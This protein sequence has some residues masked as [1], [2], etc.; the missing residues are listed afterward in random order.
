MLYADCTPPTVERAAAGAARAIEEHSIAMQL[1][2]GCYNRSTQEKLLQETEINLTNFQR[3]MEADET[4]AASSAALRSAQPLASIAMTSSHD[5]TKAQQ[6]PKQQHHTPTGNSSMD[7]SCAGCRGHAYKS[8]NCL[9][10]GKQCKGC[11]ATNHF[12]KV[13]KKSRQK[14]NLLTIGNILHDKSPPHIT[15]AIEIECNGNRITTQVMVDTGADISTVQQR[16]VRHLAATPQ[17]KPTTTT[18]S[19]FDKSV[20]RQVLG[21]LVVTVRHG[22]KKTQA[23]L[24]VVTDD[25]PAVAGRDLIQAL[26]LSINGPELQVMSGTQD[27]TTERQIATTAMDNIEH[28]PGV[29]NH[30]ADALSRLPRPSHECAVAEDE[31]VELNATIATLQH[32]PISLESIQQH[33]DADNVLCKVRKYMYIVS[34]RPNKKG[35]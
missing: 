33:T 31:A 26:G 17:V 25:M 34:R 8:P 7:K 16:T 10:F 19:N 20:I 12:L 24:Y 2:I 29:H 27:T 28:I 4:A 9:A 23:T 5:K 11:G 6:C 14:L 13:C 18:V 21:L 1:A 15:T 35:S 30:M 32:G 22:N 3:I